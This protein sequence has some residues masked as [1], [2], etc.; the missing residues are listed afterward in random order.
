LVL[1]NPLFGTGVPPRL[2]ADL[3]ADRAAASLVRRACAAMA[4]CETQADGAESALQVIG[5]MAPLFLTKPGLRHSFAELRYRLFFP[6]SPLHL[7]VWPFLWPILTLLQ[8]PRFVLKRM[9]VRRG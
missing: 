5:L 4:R 2:L 6:Y 3:R 8:L 9:R 7:A 1:C